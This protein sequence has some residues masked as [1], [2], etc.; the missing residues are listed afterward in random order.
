[1]NET[2]AKLVDIVFRD[3]ERT[4]E[5]QILYEQVRMDCQERFEDLI[6][7]GMD[8]DE[9]IA[10]VVESLKGME[11]VL[12]DYPLRKTEE[13][14]SEEKKV[15]QPSQS[16]IDL[17]KDAIESIHVTVYSHDVYI[18]RSK[19]E[20]VH[21]Y[22]EAKEIAIHSENH[23][24]CV[25]EKK[26]NLNK[27]EFFFSILRMHNLPDEPLYIEIPEKNSLSADISAG[28][29][30]I[31]WEGAELGSAMLKT[32]SG[33]IHLK[34][35]ECH[36]G[37][38]EIRSTSG[39]VHLHDDA[40]ADE[41]I[42]STTSGDIRGSVQCGR[43]EAHTVSGDM[44]IHGKAR[45]LHADTL[46]GELELS[47]TYD[48]AWCKSMSG[49]LDIDAACNDML[50]V[51]TSGD[52]HLSGKNHTV[53]MQSTSGDIITTVRTKEIQCTTTSG[54]VEMNVR[55]SEELERVSAETRSGD[56]Q[57]LLPKNQSYRVHMNTNS[58][59]SSARVT[60]SLDEDAPDVDVRS[61]SG[62]IRIQ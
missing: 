42:I 36:I 46:S 33:D 24:I 45:E 11:E 56:V 10:A 2:V 5:V 13:V 53:K 30:E 9:A 12:K 43:M 23:A 7:N 17:P 32:T 59:D 60:E 4:E 35:Q 21:V 14:A 19:D 26:V 41:M 16:R 44:A 37:K 39:D 29:G 3:T 55:E 61:V 18:L 47:G 28:I 62:D 22:T 50:A 6:R 1:M 27:K 57:V 51:S 8:E 15:A 48:T 58:G 40:D 20:K 31:F 34:G 49:D 54:D 25:E 52:I 38:M